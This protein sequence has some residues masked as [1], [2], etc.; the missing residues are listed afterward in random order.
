MQY[1]HVHNRILQ[2][3]FKYSVNDISKHGAAITF[4][5]MCCHIW[6]MR[7][8]PVVFCSTAV[9]Q[10]TTACNRRRPLSLWRFPRH[11]GWF[12]WQYLNVVVILAFYMLTQPLKSDILDAIKTI[13]LPRATIVAKCQYWTNQTVLLLYIDVPITTVIA[14]SLWAY[15]GWCSL[16][17][18]TDSSRGKWATNPQAPELKHSHIF[19]FTTNWH[20]FIACLEHPPGSNANRYIMY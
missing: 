10:R 19:Q 18:I 7:C 5:H 15:Y 16:W 4:L 12:K 9:E 2:K 8:R 14:G 20:D 13:C 1:R 11:I 6:K 17:N 3:E